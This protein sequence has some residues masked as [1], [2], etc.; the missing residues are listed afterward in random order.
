MNSQLELNSRKTALSALSILLLV[1][2]VAY[3]ESLNVLFNIWAG[4]EQTIHNY[5]FLVLACVLYLLYL[6]IDQFRKLAVHPNF[7]ALLPAVA[8]S[9]TWFVATIADV[10]TVQLA[11]LP[12]IL[13]SAIAAIL[14]TS[15]LKLSLVPVALLL[16]AMPIWWPL[17]PYLKDATTLVTEVF[18]RLIDRPVFREGY[19]LHLPGGSFFVDDGCAG[20]RFFLVTLILIFMSI[21][22]HGLSVRKGITLLASGIGLALLAN[23]IRVIIIVLVGDATQ[24]E[25]RLVHDHND[26]GWLVYSIVVLI[27]F[28]ILIRRFSFPDM[29]VVQIAK[30]ATASSYITPHQM[31]I[32]ALAVI[33][34]ATGPLLT[35]QL[36]SQVYADRNVSPPANSGGW[37][38]LETDTEATSSSWRPNY[39]NETRL[40]ADSYVKSNEKVTLHI[41]NYAD[42]QAGAEVVNVDNTLV[43]D[44]Q[45]SVVADSD[46]PI[47]VNT[48]NGTSLEL[49]TV[50]IQGPG[51]S[52]RLVWYW[53]EIGRFSTNN[54][55]AAKIFQIVSL[56]EQ[57]RDGNLITV[58][59]ECQLDCM[60][61]EN[62]LSNF[63]ASMYSGIKSGL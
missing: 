61:A 12:L 40:L 1:F 42:Q 49:Q 46:M 13:L 14:G 20:L 25:N 8:S 11:V 54:M 45:W 6:K 50:Q 24:M 37:S 44:E 33:A 58:S 19:Y 38:V 63:V 23:W 52:R 21:D 31:A 7:W 2:A 35:M 9:V 15:Y 28:F 26:L 27:P 60:G 16:F 55:Y 5:G 39:S 57:R 10:Q 48:T 43:D 30:S 41:V 36:R 34:L 29:P 51:N 18:L 3:L 47:S 32:V 4:I 56:L 22:M 62:S 59:A 53:Y 17:L